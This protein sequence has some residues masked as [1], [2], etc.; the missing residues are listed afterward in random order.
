M[1]E[2]NHRH[3]SNT[4]Y[5]ILKW[6]ICSLMRAERVRVKRTQFP[7]NNEKWRRTILTKSKIEKYR[8]LKIAFSFKIVQIP[9]Q[10]ICEPS[11]YDPKGQSMMTEQTLLLGVPSTKV[12]SHRR[13]LNIPFNCWDKQ[14]TLWSSWLNCPAPDII[15]DTQ[16]NASRPDYPK[17]N[18]GYVS[19]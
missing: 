5:M 13:E 11:Y 4:G 8:F 7:Q 19:L 10:V 12:P 9:F 15:W 1:L 3:E 17:T 18:R 16:Q 2:Q 14:N 6:F